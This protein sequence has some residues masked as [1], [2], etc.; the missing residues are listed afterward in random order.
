MN[1][2]SLKG[3]QPREKYHSYK[4]V[5]GKIAG[6]LLRRNFR[7]ARPNEKWAT[8][9]TQFNLPFGKCY[10]SP[11]LDMYNNEIVSYD[12]SQSPNFGQTTKMLSRAFLSRPDVNGMI[13]HSDQ[14]WQ[15]QMKQYTAALKAR[16]IIQSMSRKGNCY[17]NSIMETFFAR[18][19][20][21]MFYGFEQLYNTFED[22]SNAVADYIDYYNNK[23]IQKKT[24]WMTPVAF[25][26]A[27]S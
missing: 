26:E 14:G 18:M 6:N 16:G 10:L 9:V 25:R 23:R 4:G 2:L 7:A 17:D 1:K 3:I 21:E 19:K 27:S 8:D 20:N 11:I 5:C 13:F 12:L 15:Y 22:F 24:M